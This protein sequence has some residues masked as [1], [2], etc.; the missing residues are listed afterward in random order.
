MQARYSAA[1]RHE[2][3][4]RNAT[5]AQ[6][7]GL[8]HVESP[9]GTPVIVY[10]RSA[11]EPKHGNFLDASYQAILAQP[12]WKRRLE[13]VHTHT[14]SLPQ[15]DERWKELDAS[16]SSDA[17]LMNIFCCPGVTESRTVALKLGFEVG[18]VPEF[19]FRACV[20]LDG[21]R[22]DRTEA[23]M[24]LGTLLAESKLTET[25]FQVQRP[26]VV[27]SYRDFR[28][29][30]D[31][32]SLPR[33]NDQYV[34]YQLIRNV[35]AARHHGLSFCVLHDA[36]R[37]DLHEA[38]FA[39]MRCVKITDLRTRCKVLTWQELAE[40]LPEPLQDFLDRKYGIVPPGCIPSPC[41][42][43]LEDVG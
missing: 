23:D 31:C 9:G 39:V 41:S 28:A 15:S 11:A 4:L 40:V 38:W 25:D 6:A 30:F 14:A 22:V 26:A 13:K 35:L 34:S 24:K 27:E 3:S 1:L 5:Y 36:R 43:D 12:E 16:T 21:G 29:V 37:P 7:R 33:L 8:S 32:D 10:K 2:L 19:G 20:P 18:E 42:S 17:L